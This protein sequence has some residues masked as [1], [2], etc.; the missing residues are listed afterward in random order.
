MFSYAFV[1]GTLTT[2]EI[3][4][5]KKIFQNVGLLYQAP[6]SIISKLYQIS[7]AYGLLLKFSPP[8]D[9]ELI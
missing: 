9:W 5:D 4:Y 1:L 3:S 7:V 6:W 8:I 2:V